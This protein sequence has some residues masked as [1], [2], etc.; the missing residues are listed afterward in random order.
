[1]SKK[2]IFS[3]VGV[4]IIAAAIAS[5]F[6]F[7]HQTTLDDG[8]SDDS[9]LLLSPSR[10]LELT[11]QI[12]DV[13][14]SGG[15]EAALQFI[16]NNADTA[17]SKAEKYFLYDRA[18]SIAIDANAESDRIIAYAIKIDDLLSNHESAAYVAN[19]VMNY[20]DTELGREY[21]QK[22]LDRLPDDEVI[23]DM[24]RQSYEGLYR[25]ML[26]GGSGE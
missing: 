23:S 11:N 8:D 6:I 14:A 16:D 21:A 3:L 20:G 7:F 25:L 19:L 9:A 12:D 26:E 17:E 15:S 5:Y 24:D 22:A 2:L 10:E 13:S 1:M 18:V 4:V